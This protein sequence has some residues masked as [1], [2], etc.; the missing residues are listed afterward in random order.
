MFSILQNWETLEKHA[1][2]QMHCECFWKDDSLRFIE[3]YARKN[4]LQKEPEK[5]ES[6]LES[7]WHEEY[8]YNYLTFRACQSCV[9]AIS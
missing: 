6:N 2:A 8:Y 3:T 1:H 5:I 4:S 7:R 9:A